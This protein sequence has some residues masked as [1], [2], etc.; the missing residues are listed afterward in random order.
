MKILS[1]A[2]LFLL[3]FSSLFG[4]KEG[5]SNGDCGCS[6]DVSPSYMG[7]TDHECPKC[8]KKGVECKSGCSYGENCDCEEEEM[9]GT[10]RAILAGLAIGVSTFILFLG[11]ILKK[12]LEEAQE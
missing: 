6:K 3:P 11:F 10:T 7:K 5:E 4:H 1:I 9:G 12:R 2:L 8:H